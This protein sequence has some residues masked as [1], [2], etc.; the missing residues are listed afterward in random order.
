MIHA[1]VLVLTRLIREGGSGLA[2][3]GLE[4]GGAGQC[5]GVGGMIG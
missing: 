4:R 3:E 1:V 5:K 2:R